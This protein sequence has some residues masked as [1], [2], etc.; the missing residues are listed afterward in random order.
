[1]AK[2]VEMSRRPGFDRLAAIIWP[3]TALPFIIEPGSPALEVM[4]TAA[5]PRGYLL[6]GAAR[7][8]GRRDEGVW[9]SLLVID[10]AGAIVANY[11][12]VHLVPLGE[13]IPFHKQLAP[14]SGLIGRGS[15]EVGE[16]RV[17]LD[18]PGLPSFSPVICYE[19][20]FPG[21]V[22]GPG[23]RPRWLLNVTNDAWFDL[24]YGPLQHLTSARL[25]AVEEGLP[26]IRVANTGV[27][28]VID[29]YGRVL[30]SLDMTEEGIIDHALPQAREATLYSRWG[31]GILLVLLA[32]M[33]SCLAV[34]RSRIGRPRG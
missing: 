5:P 21:A 15:F 18:V 30:A 26:M 2:L 29:A 14:V 12:K 33:A 28:A 27:S 4:A 1:M 13:Y 31:D 20:I 10:P 25:R 11:D 8:T 16:D 19:V 23:A 17:T 22:T 7:G 6:T 3:E 32:L 24:S 9:N 34:G